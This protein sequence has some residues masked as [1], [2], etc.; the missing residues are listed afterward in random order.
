MAENHPNTLYA[1][2][3]DK[4]K[5]YNEGMKSEVRGAKNIAKNETYMLLSYQIVR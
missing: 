2:S 1:L 5:L 3:T 4:E